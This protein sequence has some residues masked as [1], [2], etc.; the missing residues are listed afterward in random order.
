M[1]QAGELSDKTSTNINASIGFGMAG[2]SNGNSNLNAAASQQ[3]SN[4]IIATA[5]SS[6]NLP[7]IPIVSEPEYPERG[8]SMFLRTH[9]SGK[10]LITQPPSRKDFYSPPTSQEMLS[11]IGTNDRSKL[12]VAPLLDVSSSGAND[13]SF[14]YTLFF[15][16]KPIK[17]YKNFV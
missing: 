7:E 3:A 17:Y 2:T 8:A 12:G 9:Q 13:S 10:N 4:A 1:K 15:K 6:A 16:R 14:I 11:Q 5:T